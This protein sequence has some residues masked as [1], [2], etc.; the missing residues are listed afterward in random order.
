MAN[1][2]Q[3]HE[4]NIEVPPI[5]K[6]TAGAVAGAALGS[7][8]GPAGAVVGGIVGAI[9]GNAAAE[10]RRN[11]QCEKRLGVC[12]NPLLR[13]SRKQFAKLPP[14][15]DQRAKL[16]KSVRPPGEVK[17]NHVEKRHRQGAGRTVVVSRRA[18]PF[19][20]LAAISRFRAFVPIR[21]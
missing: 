2:A 16:R 1:E 6:A 4:E 7:V 11:P 9:A 19:A 17:R 10:G 8:M 13:A 18:N 20:V 5:P 15:E 3:V 14:N 12:S 21:G